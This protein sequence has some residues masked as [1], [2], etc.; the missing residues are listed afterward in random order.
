MS[1][2]DHHIARGLKRKPLIAGERHARLGYLMADVTDRAKREEDE[3]MA[4][5]VPTVTI[6]SLGMV[7][8]KEPV[9]LFSTFG[10]FKA[11]GT[12]MPV[13][14]ILHLK[15]LKEVTLELQGREQGQGSWTTLFRFN[16]EPFP[17]E[18]TEKEMDRILEYAKVNGFMLVDFIDTGNGVGVRGQFSKR[19]EKVG[20][21]RFWYV[22]ELVTPVTPH[23]E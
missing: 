22:L 4:C 13:R 17:G 2:A 7:D 8:L 9:D 5:P 16:F 21:R 15:A 11:M 10:R 23:V 3:L 19:H 1:D 12:D 14:A 6:G 20:D 18:E